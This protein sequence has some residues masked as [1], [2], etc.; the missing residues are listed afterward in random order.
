MVKQAS[1]PFASAKPVLLGPCMQTHTARFLT[2]LSDCLQVEGI[3][4]NC[5]SFRCHLDDDS[6][7]AGRNRICHPRVRLAGRRSLSWRSAGVDGDALRI[8]ARHHA[9][10]R[11]GV[12][13]VAGGVL[14]RHS[15][16]EIRVGGSGSLNRLRHGRSGLWR[17]GS[18]HGLIGRDMVQRAIPITVGTSGGQQAKR[19]REMFFHGHDFKGQAWALP[20]RPL[21][22]QPPTA[23][24][25][26]TSLTLA[27]NCLRPN[28]LGRK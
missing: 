22:H 24:P 2:I 7:T 4:A 26:S 19:E 10:L 21:A 17:R 15:A 1:C 23:A 8:T 20:T 25:A 5:L 3:P 28:G 18:R 12:E 9:C 13:A 14:C 16:A 6:A 27:A 11:G